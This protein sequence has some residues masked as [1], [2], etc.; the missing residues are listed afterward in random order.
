MPTDPLLA[1]MTPRVERAVARMQ[2]ALAQLRDD[3]PAGHLHGGNS[4]GG[5][6]G[7]GKRRIG[8][9]GGAGCPEYEVISVVAQL[10]VGAAPSPR[11]GVFQRGSGC[12]TQAP[13]A[14]PA[15]IFEHRRPLRRGEG[16]APTA[17]IGSG[18]R[19]GANHP[20]RCRRKRRVVYPSPP[21]CLRRSRVSFWPTS[22]STC[23]GTRRGRA[24]HALLQRFFNL[25][26]PS[27]NSMLIRLEQRGFICRTPGKARGIT[28][29]IDPG[30]IP[31]LD[32]PFRG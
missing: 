31:E 20:I 3:T 16:A 5:S 28:L 10:P 25:T 13:Y 4:L 26:A 30:M 21:I 14:R 7:H 27:V 9:G 24:A 12:C 11:R 18:L 15:L 2:A 29:V 1:K 17:R 32:C 22:R 8:H 6:G 23:C 19:Y